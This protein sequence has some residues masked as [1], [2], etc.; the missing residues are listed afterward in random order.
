VGRPIWTIWSCSAG[1]TTVS[2]MNTDGASM[3]IP[4]GKRCSANPTDR[5]TH[6]QDP[7]STPDSES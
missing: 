5:T 1:S 4:T 2:S 3:T 6:H 7:G